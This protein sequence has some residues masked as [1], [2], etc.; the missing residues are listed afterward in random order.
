MSLLVIHASTSIVAA[1]VLALVRGWLMLI[2]RLV[3]VAARFA[4]IL[5]TAMILVLSI[6]A[7][8]AAPRKAVVLLLMGMWAH[9]LLAGSVLKGSAAWLTPV[10]ILAAS[11][12]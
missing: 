3:S 2:P 11:A 9:A 7:R 8:H 10:P 1:V 6:M 12:I 5:F 4:A